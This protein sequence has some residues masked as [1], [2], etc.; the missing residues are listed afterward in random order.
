MA[1]SSQCQRILRW[2]KDC[3]RGDEPLDRGDGVRIEHDLDMIDSSRAK[4]RS[5]SASTSG[6]PTS[7]RADRS[8]FGS[9]LGKSIWTETDRAS[10]VGSRPT[11]RQPRRRPGARAHGSGGVVLPGQP[12]V[13]HVSVGGGEREDTWS[14]GQRA[15]HQ[16]RPV[17]T[18]PTRPQLTLPPYT[19]GHGNRP[20]RCAGVGE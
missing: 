9:A 20:I 16:R 4:A 14:I 12:G 1:P 5:A 19:S 6:G 11:A 3:Q 18:R 8:R 2:P 7:G 13:P 15:D 17:W 10:V